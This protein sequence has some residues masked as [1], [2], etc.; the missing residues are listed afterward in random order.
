MKNKISLIIILFLFSIGVTYSQSIEDGWY[1]A[2]VEVGTL[3]TDTYILGV[4]VELDKVVEIDFGTGGSI[5]TGVNTSNYVY[6]GGTLFYTR[7][8]LDNIIAADA[9]VSIYKNGNVINY[10]ISIE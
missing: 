6:Y 3:Y 10:K 5:H 9:T 7:D 2:R 1:K 8:H 4:K